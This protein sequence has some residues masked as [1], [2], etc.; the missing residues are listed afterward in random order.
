MKLPVKAD[1]AF[2]VLHTLVEQYGRGPISIREL[3]ERN[4]VPKSFLEH[5]ML[6]LKANGWVSSL[7]GKH[8]GYTLA[9]SPHAIKLG[10]IIRYFDG[11][12]EP[13]GMA[14]GTDDRACRTEI[15]NDPAHRF[16][17]MMREVRHQA[18]ELMD[19]TTLASVFAGRPVS[20]DEVLAQEY[21]SGGGI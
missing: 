5:I 20:R 18:A 11:L 9:K 6:E 3:A 16:R 15:S 13:D 14:Q 17:R 8:G 21:V 2:R 10:E 1:Y 7:P 19:T 12:S 4:G